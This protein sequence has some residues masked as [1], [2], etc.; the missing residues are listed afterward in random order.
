MA[1][2]A[3]AMRS[4]PL[5][6]ATDAAVEGSPEEVEDFVTARARRYPNQLQHGVQC[7]KIERDMKGT[8]IISVHG[9]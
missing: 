1:C 9:L 2:L 4:A 5:P 6:Q 7:L 3:W 8:S